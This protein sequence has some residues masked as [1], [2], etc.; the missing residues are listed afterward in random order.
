MAVGTIYAAVPAVAAAVGFYFFDRNYSK[1]KEPRGGI[2]SY[3]ERIV[4]K[5]KE[6]MKTRQNP[7]L[8]PQFDGLHCYE[9]LVGH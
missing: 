5:V 9:T 4:P 1:S 8:A 6:E 7:K 2:W 3:N